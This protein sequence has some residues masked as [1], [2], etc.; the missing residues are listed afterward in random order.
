MYGW[1]KGLLA[2]KAPDHVVVEC[3]GVGY[4]LNVSLYSYEHLPKQGQEAKVLAHLVVTEDTHT[5]YGFSSESERSLFR[6][7]VKVSG[8]G[9]N[10]ARMILSALPPSEL[11]QAIINADVALLKT[12]KGIGAKTAQRM[13][14]DLQNELS[15]EPVDVA[16]QLGGEGAARKEA[17]TAL[18][19]LGFSSTVADKALAKVAKGAGELTVE[20]LIKQALKHL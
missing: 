1:F 10:T 15:K 19:A 16:L 8:I 2:E 7:L 18:V 9:P 17:Q 3:G 5:L 12:V 20:E 11:R 4:Q 6:R 14:V 13:V